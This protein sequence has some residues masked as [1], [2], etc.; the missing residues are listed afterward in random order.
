MIWCHNASAIDITAVVNDRKSLNRFS[1]NG[2]P[3]PVSR[4]I[5]DAYA[6]NFDVAIERCRGAKDLFTVFTQNRST[7][8]KCSFEEFKFSAKGP[9]LALDSR[10]NF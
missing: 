3:A 7:D 8:V 9:S 1:S 6:T 5:L 2:F 10:R 4:D